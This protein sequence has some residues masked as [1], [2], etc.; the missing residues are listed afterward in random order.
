MTEEIPLTGEYAYYLS[1]KQELLRSFE[2]KFA[3]IKERELVGI[4]DTDEA[5]YIAGLKRFGN[6]P[7]LIVPVEQE[8][9]RL[10]IPV[11][12]LGFSDAHL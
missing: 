3:L 11:L 12:E 8:E 5:A 7:F 2:G 10:W 9:E 6:V 4:F 1:R